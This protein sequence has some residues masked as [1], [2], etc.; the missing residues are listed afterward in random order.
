MGFRDLDFLRKMNRPLPP[1]SI[2]CESWGSATNSHQWQPVHRLDF[3]YSLRIVGFRDW[4]WAV[5]A[6]LALEAFSIP[7]ESWGSA[8]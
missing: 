2:P 4:M 7:C 5:L 6:V 1:F 3:Q 8:T